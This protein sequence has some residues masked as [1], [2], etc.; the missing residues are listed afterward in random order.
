M[1]F[2]VIESEENYFLWNIQI[3]HNKKC[4]QRSLQAECQGCKLKTFCLEQFVSR[5][6]NQVGEYVPK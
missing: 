3:L 4:L 1:V 2:R 6:N 5:L